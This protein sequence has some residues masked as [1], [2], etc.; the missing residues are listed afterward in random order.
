MAFR[1]FAQ[2]D[3]DN[4]VDQVVL[5]DFPSSD[6]ES[7]G[8]Q[9]CKDI[10]GNDKTFV[11]CFK[12]ADGTSSTRYNMAERGMIWDPD[13]NCFKKSS[14]P[15]PSWTLN[16]TNYRWE[17]PTAEPAYPEDT[18]CE[19]YKWDEPNTRWLRSENTDDNY[20]Q[21]WDPST[22]TWTDI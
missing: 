7:V 2:I 6:A 5:L 16:T 22:N 19:D 13:N 14:G 12:T 17:P 11:E 18:P 21:Y 9:M 15:Y 4:N 8:I 1:T 20:N 3:N 10:Y